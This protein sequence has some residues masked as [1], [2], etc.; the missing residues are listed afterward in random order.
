MQRIMGSIPAEGKVSFCNFFGSLH[1]IEASIEFEETRGVRN[2]NL[3]LGQNRNCRSLAKK[4]AQGHILI[5][6]SE[7][8]N[9]ISK[10]GQTMV[11]LLC[12]TPAQMTL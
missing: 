9:A 3:A 10:L 5:S 7:D 12:N 4:Q 8:A 11:T 6:I 1:F 2:R